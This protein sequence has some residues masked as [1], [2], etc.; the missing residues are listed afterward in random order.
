MF[1]ALPVGPA[2]PAAVRVDEHDPLRVARQ[3]RAPE[4]LRHALVAQL[5]AG[6]GQQEGGAAPEQL[7]VPRRHAEEDLQPLGAARGQP[8]GGQDRRPQAGG[9]G[10]G[11]HQE[12]VGAQA[13]EEEVAVAHRGGAVSVHDGAVCMCTLVESDLLRSTMRHLKF[14]WLLRDR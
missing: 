14:I 2:P 9:E 1:K 10:L 3:R 13:E 11:G 8:G 7:E 6:D 5:G 12:E 4:E